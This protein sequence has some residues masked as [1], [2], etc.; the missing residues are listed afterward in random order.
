MLLVQPGGS[1]VP[2]PRV[3]GPGAGSASPIG[4]S[5]SLGGHR[6]ASSVI[7]ISPPGEMVVP[8]PRHGALES[9]L[10]EWG[11]RH[12]STAPGTVAEPAEALLAEIA[13]GQMSEDSG[14]TS[15]PGEEASAEDAG[16]LPEVD[17]DPGA[18][19][20]VWVASGLIVAGARL[21]FQRLRQRR[22]GKVE[23]RPA[24]EDGAKGVSKK[25][26]SVEN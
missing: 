14:T 18:R 10:A 24:A 21:G 5:L 16:G 9:I 13:Q 4:Q 26:K 2:A 17:G 1:S 20:R 15:R 8:D 25:A 11:S 3:Q 19:L 6:Y 23:V 12:S 22:Q 7:L